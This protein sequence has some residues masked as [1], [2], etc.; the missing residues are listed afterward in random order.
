MTVTDLS[1]AHQQGI[2]PLFKGLQDMLDIHLA[3]A[4]VFDDPH[5]MGILEPQGTGHIRRRISTV[6]ADHGDEFRFEFHTKESGGA[7]S[8]ER[9][10]VKYKT[11]TR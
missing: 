5:V 6:G 1:A 7:R 11:E 4:E 8:A 2:G 10:A 9:R 3:G